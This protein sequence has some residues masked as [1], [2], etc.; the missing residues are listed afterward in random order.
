MCGSDGGEFCWNASQPPYI[1][2]VFSTRRGG[3]HHAVHSWWRRQRA[4]DNAAAALQRWKQS[5]ITRYELR[6]EMLLF[7][8]DGLVLLIRELHRL[9]LV[10]GWCCQCFSFAWWV[11]TNSFRVAPARKVN[12]PPVFSRKWHCG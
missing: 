1:T 4:A 5:P 6:W 12:G 10:Q 3:R 9:G 2:M 8:V 11:L 7:T